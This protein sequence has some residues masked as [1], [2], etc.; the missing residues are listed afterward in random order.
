MRS[1]GG[2]KNSLLR[3]SL[4]ATEYAVAGTAITDGDALA[5][6]VGRR[7][8]T[9][10][11][12]DGDSGSDE[13]SL[14]NLADH[15][16]CPS[17]FTQESLMMNPLHM[18]RVLVSEGTEDALMVDISNVATMRQ[19]KE[20]IIAKAKAEGLFNGVQDMNDFVLHFAESNCM[21]PCEIVQVRQGDRYV[22]Y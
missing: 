16:K 17:S 18:A 1:F 11:E 3:L 4:E 9:V 15:A 14:E 6:D 19:L 21:V 10:V 13:V 8:S 7:P 2:E 12:E 22:L 20:E 5:S